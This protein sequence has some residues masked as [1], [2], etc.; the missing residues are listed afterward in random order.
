[1]LTSI[2]TAR[3]VANRDVSKSTILIVD[4]VRHNVQVLSQLVRNEGHRVIAA[5]DGNDALALAR[6][7]KPDLVLMDV[8]M[9]EMDGYSVCEQFKKDPILREI[10]I[11]FLSA[12]S[13]VESKVRGF[14]VGG[15]DYITKPFHQEEVVARINLHLTLKNLEQERERYIA[16]LKIRERNLEIANREKDEVIRIVS[17]DI[18]NPLTGIIGVANILRSEDGYSKEEVDGMLEIIEQSGYKLLD[19]VKDILEVESTKAG[20]LQ[21]NLREVSLQELLDQV[22]ELHQPTALT[23]SINLRFMKDDRVPAMLIDPQK[24]NQAISN[25]VAN[26]LKFTGAGG[27]IKLILKFDEESNDELPVIVEVKDTGIGIPE[28]RLPTLFD[29]IKRHRGT[30]TKGEKGTGIGLD[31]VKQFIELHGGNIS[32]TSTEG[33]GTSFKLELPYKTEKTHV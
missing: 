32:V 14:E 27:S 11:I 4:D 25:L 22:I 3:P 33:K 5:F 26:S 17:H 2:Q 15:V 1:M 21:L 7:R 19:L 24:I 18:R 8:L 6:K 20:S 16:E 10:P 23:K 28:D 29:S 9:P 12:L 13:D 30:G 31:I